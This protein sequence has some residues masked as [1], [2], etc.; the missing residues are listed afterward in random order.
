MTE[1]WRKPLYEV[2][3]FR[4]LL[5]DL[6]KAFDCFPHQLLI[7]K[8]YDYGV[9]IPSLKLLHS[10][11]TKWKQNVKLK[12]NGTYGLW[13]EIIFGV[14]QGSILGPLPLNI[15]QWGL[16]RFF[17]DLDMTNYADYNIPHSTNINLN[18]NKFK[19]FIQM[20]HRWSSEGKRRKATS[21]C[22]LNTRN[23]NLHWWNG[24]LQ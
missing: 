4:A 14:P 13:W 2:D 22:E 7:T 9:D 6:S 23:S 21:Y 20:V 5:T 11:L 17:A 8:L 15:F 3:A 16:F 10:Y 12:L 1:K 24:H 18:S 19:Y